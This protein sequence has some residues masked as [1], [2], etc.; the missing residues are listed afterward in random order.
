MVT[1]S[2]ELASRPFLTRGPGKLFADGQ[3]DGRAEPPRAPQPTPAGRFYVYFMEAL[4]GDGWLDMVV[5]FSSSSSSSTLWNVS[6]FE[7]GE[8]S[9][10]VHD[11][12]VESS[13]CVLD[14]LNR[15]GGEWHRSTLI[16]KSATRIEIDPCQWKWADK[17]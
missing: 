14:Q 10:D 1:K 5:S 8:L 11:A 7:H 6:E 15:V 12:Y 2:L 16:P 17:K 3:P 4:P 13:F 9:R